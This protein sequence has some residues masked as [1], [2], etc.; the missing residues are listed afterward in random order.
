DDVVYWVTNDDLVRLEQP[1]LSQ[2]DVG[3]VAQGGW[4]VGTAL[5]EEGEVGFVA[6]IASGTFVSFETFPLMD[7]FGGMFVPE[8]VDAW[9]NVA[10][11]SFDRAGIPTASLKMLGDA[12]IHDLGVPAE[13]S[14]ISAMNDHGYIVGTTA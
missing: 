6:Q 1:G 11:R 7:S 9:G 2:L 5:A 13:G 4:M 14:T 10:G 3:G 8:T 12:Q